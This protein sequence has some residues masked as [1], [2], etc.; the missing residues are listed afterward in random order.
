MIHFTL[1]GLFTDS[2]EERQDFYDRLAWGD[3][4]IWGHITIWEG[5]G[6]EDKRNETRQV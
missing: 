6:K 3:P 1:D 5:A 4:V 2:E